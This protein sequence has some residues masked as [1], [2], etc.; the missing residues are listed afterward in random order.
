MQIHTL[1]SEVRS[2][3]ISAYPAKWVSALQQPYQTICTIACHQSKVS[4]TVGK[5]ATAQVTLNS[6]NGVPA[7]DSGSL[8]EDSGHSTEASAA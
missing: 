6:K 3:Q 1:V 8:E 7:H 2:L 4:C 5:L